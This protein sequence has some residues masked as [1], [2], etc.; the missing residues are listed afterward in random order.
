MSHFED[1]NPLLSLQFAI[2]FDR[3]R[4]EQVE[5]GIKELLAR[6]EKRVLAIETES[7]PR[8]F[9][10]TL[11]ALESATEELDVAMS[12]VSHVES[13]ATTPEW[14]EAYNRVRPEVS[15][16]YASLPLRPGVWAALKAFA[17]TAEAKSLSATRARFL[18]KTLDDFRRNGADLAD[19]GKQRL[20]AISRELAE[21]TTKFSQNVVDATAEFE[22]ILENESD[23]AG[24][25][26]SAIAG[27]REDAARKNLSGYRFTLQAPSLIP[28]LTY[29]D[30]A[31]I[32]ER[33]F[34]ASNT[35]AATG[36][37]AN[38]P[39]ISK[40]IE[41]RREQA[42]LLG[43]A[44]FADF[45][46]EDRMAKNYEAARRFVADL[47]TRTRPAFER[48]TRALIEFRNATSGSKSTRLDPWDVAYYSEKMRQQLYEF[49]EEELRPYFRM[50]QVVEGLFETARRL[51]GVKV[52]ANQTLPVW[53]P[54][55][56]AFDLFDEQGVFLAAFYTDFYPRDEKRGGA[57]MNSLITGV[58]AAGKSTPHLGLICANVTPPTLDRPALLT[59]QEVTTLFHE[60]GHLLHHCLSRV[61]VRTL[62]GTNVAWDFVELPSQIM[63]N[64]CWER[65]ALDSF[66]RHYKTG[67]AIPDELFAKMLRARTFREA[68]ATMRQLGFATVDLDLH[69]SYDPAQSNLVTRAREIMQEFSAST[70][71]E[72]YAMIASFSHLFAGAV[73]YAAGYYSYKWAEVLD[74]D[75]FTRFK[76]EGVFS[77]QVGQAFRSSIL[78]RGDSD[79]P[80]SLYKAFM[81][82]EPSLQ[83]LLERSGLL[84][85]TAPS[86][87]SA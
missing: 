26:E 51:Y 35:R 49:D 21:L 69:V 55:V 4:A 57:W 59:H 41:L 81:G 6:S 30:D 48:E 79:D 34:R 16:F 71:P 31:Q 65:A 58:H 39:L 14:R 3:L 82:R 76:A 36:K 47:T 77:R 33:M 40:I 60:F 86:Q 74:A 15:A 45:V 75:A 46:L 70:L 53:H 42:R 61:D 50:E 78:E 25:P 52:E 29:L 9:A 83:P 80:M 27:A 87:A 18:H 84:T 17:E 12:V 67:E 66:A 22:L 7:A 72:D 5:P 44:N 28:L 23:L 54:D 11:A 73:G 13:V 37:L 63:E 68:S 85:Q 62:A 19:V 24:L 8:T 20:E 56:R 64:W 1:Q 32:R 43:Y 10:N 38:P 2:P